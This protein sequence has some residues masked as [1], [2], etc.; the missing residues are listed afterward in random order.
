MFWVRVSVTGGGRLFDVRV[1][2]IDE[3][4]CSGVRVIIIGK[5]DVLGESECHRW[6][7]VV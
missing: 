6:R 1:S 3:D 7:T 4:A 5:E 2:A